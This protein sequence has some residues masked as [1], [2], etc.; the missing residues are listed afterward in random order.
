M[1]D[2]GLGQGIGL[3]GRLSP[4]LQALAHPLGRAPAKQHRAKVEDDVHARSI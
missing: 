2:D 3:L 1:G 4:W